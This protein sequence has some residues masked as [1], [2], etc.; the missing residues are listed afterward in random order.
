MP[1]I[2]NVEIPSNKCIGI[3]LTY[4]YGI[5]R[6]L[7]Q[8]ILQKANIDFNKKTSNLKENE[9][10][11]IRNIIQ[12]EYKV[13]GALREQIRSHIKRLQEI[14]AYRGLRH[15]RKLPARGQNTRTNART[16]RGNVRRTVATGKKK[17]PDKT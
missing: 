2:A 3:A 13:E 15:N 11:L 8:E 12:E 7:A 5:G 10:M 17:A 14:H 1:R 4:I 16:V 6:S 9:I